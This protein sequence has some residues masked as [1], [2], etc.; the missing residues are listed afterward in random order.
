MLFRNR[1]KNE[2]SRRYRLEMQ[3]QSRKGR[4]SRT[5]RDGGEREYLIVFYGSWV[6]ARLPG[7]GGFFG[8]HFLDEN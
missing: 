6:I 5:R 4:E 3:A 2:I 7:D 1:G 8:K